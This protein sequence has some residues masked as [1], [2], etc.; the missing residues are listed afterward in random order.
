[1]GRNTDSRTFSIESVAQAALLSVTHVERLIEAK[2]VRAKRIGGA[3]RIYA[4]QLPKF[5]LEV[6]H[7]RP[8]DTYDERAL[9]VKFDHGYWRSRGY[10]DDDSERPCLCGC[11][12][13]T[14]G[15]W[16]RGHHSRGL[17]HT[18]TTSYGSTANFLARHDAGLDSN[19]KLPKNARRLMT[20]G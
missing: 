11:G 19:R 3:Y 4:D 2:K 15:M 1:M 20:K 12:E 6:D 5:E 14:K 13:L 8:I 9:A 16:R 18:L 7:L 10:L 17:Y